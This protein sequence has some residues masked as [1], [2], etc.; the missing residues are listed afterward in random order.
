M[1]Q[2]NE[3]VKGGRQWKPGG[4][5]HLTGIVVKIIHRITT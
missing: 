2:G 1:L 5:S 3:G 4:E